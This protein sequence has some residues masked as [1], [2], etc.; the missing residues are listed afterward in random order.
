MVEYFLL[1]KPFVFPYFLV[2]T[3]FTDLLTKNGATSLGQL[4]DLSSFVLSNNPFCSFFLS[5]QKIGD[6]SFHQLDWSFCHLAITLAFHL[7]NL[8]FHQ[9]VI[10]STWHF[11]NM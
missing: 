5:Q 7:I 10:S 8:S 1:L 6:W 11:M 2:S 4:A 9:F 3:K